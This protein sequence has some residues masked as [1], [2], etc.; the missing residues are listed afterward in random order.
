MYWAVVKELKIFDS[1]L[2]HWYSVLNRLAQNVHTL[3][4]ELSNRYR[5]GIKTKDIFDNIQIFYPTD[6]PHTI[7]V[8]CSNSNIQHSAELL[9]NLVRYAI[10]KKILLKRMH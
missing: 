9:M 7:H 1:F 6:D 3:E 4:R 8:D 10:T 2:N 5:I